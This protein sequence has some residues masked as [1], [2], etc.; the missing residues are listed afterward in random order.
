MKFLGHIRDKYYKLI[1]LINSDKKSKYKIHTS[2]SG[3]I[4]IITTMKN[5]H[6]QRF[7]KLKIILEKI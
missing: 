6:I 5:K 2:K 4:Y 1:N 7:K 3:S